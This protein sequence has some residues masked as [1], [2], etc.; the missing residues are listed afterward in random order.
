[1]EKQV[2]WKIDN[3]HVKPFASAKDVTLLVTFIAFIQ[4]NT[5]TRDNNF[6]LGDDDDD[7]VWGFF[8]LQIAYS[9]S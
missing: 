7:G 9:K 6:P 8:L 1:M 3:Y 4:G 2:K 5:E